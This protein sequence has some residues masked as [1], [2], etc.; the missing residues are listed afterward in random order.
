M[1]SELRHRL[2]RLGPFVGLLLV[3]A[4]FALA[5]G[6]PSATCPPTTC[7]WSSPRP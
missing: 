3:V 1:R 7:A 2:V 5:S 6:A 4:F